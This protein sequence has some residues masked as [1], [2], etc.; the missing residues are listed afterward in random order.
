LGGGRGRDPSLQIVEKAQSISNHGGEGYLGIIDL[1]Q[2][3]D[4]VCG[5][6]ITGGEVQSGTV[7]GPEDGIIRVSP[8]REN[9]EG[10][11]AS[12]AVERFHG[13]VEY[14]LCGGALRD[15]QSRQDRGRP[16]EE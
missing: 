11:G 1:F 12:G 6:K 4:L 8:M 5:I 3:V 14:G 10:S 2:S 16:A 13:G 15:I 9:P 7:R